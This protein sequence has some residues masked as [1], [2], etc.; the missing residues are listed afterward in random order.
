MAKF[1]RQ[2]FVYRNDLTFYSSCPLASI[3]NGG[4]SVAG[5]VGGTIIGVIAFVLLALVLIVSI[6]LFLERRRT[7]K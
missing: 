7:S 3:R 6:A 1:N 4:S 2:A 5:I